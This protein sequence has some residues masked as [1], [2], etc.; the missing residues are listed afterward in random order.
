[1]KITKEQDLILDKFN[2]VHSV[3][4]YHRG[5]LEALN[6]F[7]RNM[8]DTLYSK[9]LEISCLKCKEVSSINEWNENN[10]YCSDCGGDHIGLECPE[11]S[12]RFSISK[13]LIHLLKEK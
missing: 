1:M 7:F 10:Y 6:Q 9:K 11:C 8:L 13:E 5:Q 12:E 4:A 3:I 2:K